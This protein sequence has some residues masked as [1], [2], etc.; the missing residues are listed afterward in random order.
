MDFTPAIYE[1][2]AR[3]I[4]RSPWDVSR[5]QQLLVEAHLKAFETYHHTP[6]IVGIDV[7]NLEAEAYGATVEQPAGNDIPAI[8]GAALNSVNE[9][10]R[11]PLFNPEQD[12]RIPMMIN[13]VKAVQGE[14][15]GVDVRF[16][17]S[18]PFSI[19]SNL[20]GFDTLLMDAFTQP[21]MVRQAL[22]HI[23]DGQITLCQACARRGLAITMFESSAT[24]PLISP[25]TFRQVELPPL[26]RLVRAAAEITNATVSC[27]IGG[28]TAPIIDDLM[29]TD[30]R[31]VI[32]P[33]ETD[34]SLFMERMRAWPEVM[35]RINMDARVFTRM[36][37]TDLRAEADRVISLARARERVCIGTGVLPYEALPETV[38]FM[39]DYLHRISDS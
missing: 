32:C 9:V 22:E 5:N 23:V 38:F 13:A 39:R 37:E 1:H 29:Q 18:G 25:D 2:A 19:L 11:L 3:I 4:G 33:Y 36:N 31:Y 35:V 26:Q 17:I 28:D 7:Y 30:A 14:L 6:V 24:P 20:V 8:V 34:Q 27:I 10:I 15:S 12:G 21:E 16:P